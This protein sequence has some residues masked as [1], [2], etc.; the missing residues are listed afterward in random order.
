MIEFV[1]WAHGGR[2]VQKASKASE[3]ASKQTDDGGF[4]LRLNYF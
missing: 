2:R 4:P 1:I 3:Q